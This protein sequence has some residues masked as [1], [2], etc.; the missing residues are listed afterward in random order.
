MFIA[1]EVSKYDENEELREGGIGS[2]KKQNKVED[3][4][5][6]IKILKAID[7][8]VFQYCIKSTTNRITFYYVYYESTVVW[9]R[10]VTRSD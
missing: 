9:C 8:S 6:S 1:S 2:T 7:Y 3:Q 5:E 10:N 4:V